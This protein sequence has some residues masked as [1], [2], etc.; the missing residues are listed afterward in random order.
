MR[1]I[2]RIK[3][4]EE[5][6]TLAPYSICRILEGGMDGFESTPEVKCEVSPSAFGSGGILILRDYAPRELSVKFE[7]TDREKYPEVRDVILK[8]MSYRGEVNITADLFGRRRSIIAYPL[9]KAEFVRENVNSVPKV[10]LKFICPDPYFTENRTEKLVLPVSEGLLTFPLNFMEG[11]GTVPSFATSGTQHKVY[12]PG[13]APC[14]FSLRI[15]AY[16]GSVTDPAVLLNGKRL[17]LMETLKEGDTA[18]FDT[19][20][21]KCG[22][23]VNGTVRYNFS[24]ESSFFT[25]EPGINHVTVMSVGDTKNLL[26]EITF[27]P[28]YAGV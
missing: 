13:D 18:V 3:A 1:C 14:G 5:K 11:S 23:S 8:I 21:G 10:K 22:V 20:R 9:G 12:N 4:G 26:A 24:R 25:L 6:L 28:C 17:Q 7:V 15:T 27:T 2:I 19:R 16:G